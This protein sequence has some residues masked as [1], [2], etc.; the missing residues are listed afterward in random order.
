[1]ARTND[2]SGDVVVNGHVL[3]DWGLHLID[4]NLTMG[5][6][7]AIVG[8]E[9]KAYSAKAK[10]VVRTR[11]RLLKR[12]MVA[13]FALALMGMDAPVEYSIE[14]IRY[15]ISPGVPVSALVVAGP[16]RRQSRCRLRHLAHSRRWAAIF[17]L[18]AGFHRERWF[19]QWTITDYLQTR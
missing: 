6:L 19:K 13:A 2:I 1:V 17:F 15:G 8:D 4:A 14:A 12:F 9:T 7:L 10:E 3:E 16:K 5:N 18:T 11:M